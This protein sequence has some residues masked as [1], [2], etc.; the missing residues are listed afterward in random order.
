MTPDPTPPEEGRRL[1]EVFGNDRLASLLSLLSLLRQVDRFRADFVFAEFDSTYGPVGISPLERER[2]LFPSDYLRL[3][4]SGALAGVVRTHREV[5]LRAPE[6]NFRTL[7][8]L[9]VQTVKATCL[10]VHMLPLLLESKTCIFYAQVRMQTNPDLGRM[11]FIPALQ[12]VA[13]PLGR[14]E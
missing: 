7:L 11:G 1:D 12:T 5:K 2:Q 3:M 9:P 13:T 10:S 4:A 14:F 6:S 8:F